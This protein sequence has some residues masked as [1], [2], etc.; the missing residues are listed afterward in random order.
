MPVL[1]R[2]LMIR[3]FTPAT[4]NVGLPVPWRIRFADVGLR[5]VPGCLLRE[6]LAF[7]STRNV[8]PSQMPQSAR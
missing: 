8:T 4:D 2:M 6:A 5:R 1:T 3:V 7:Q